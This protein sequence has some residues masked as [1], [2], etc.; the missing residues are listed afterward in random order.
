MLGTIDHMGERHAYRLGKPAPKGSSGVAVIVGV[1]HLRVVTKGIDLVKGIMIIDA[2]FVT[3]DRS[4][5]PL[6]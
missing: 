6:L 4:Y 2:L 3:L 5:L 1:E